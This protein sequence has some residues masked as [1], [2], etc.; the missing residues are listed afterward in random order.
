M[1]EEKDEKTEDIPELE[2]ESDEDIKKEKKTRLAWIIFFVVMVL[3]ITSCIVVIE[4][5]K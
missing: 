1:K 2:I 5:L 4:V 3:L